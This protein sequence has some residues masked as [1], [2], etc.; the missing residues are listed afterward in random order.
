M[1][2]SLISIR[3][4]NAADAAVFKAIRLHALQE[5]SSAFGSSYEEEKDRTEEQWVQ[6]VSPGANRNIIGAFE[7]NLLI[8]IVGVGRESGLKC[9]HAGF[10]RTMFVDPAYRDRGVGKA[11][12][13]NA[14]EKARAMPGLD[15]LTLAVN[16]TNEAAIRLYRAMGFVEY[17]RYPRALLVDGQFHDE[18]LMLKSL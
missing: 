5:S 6:F 12:V 8:G 3:V 2:S 10:I 11:L 17:G 14:I 18:L 15:H 1:S 9:T 4:L 13:S 16:A 7:N